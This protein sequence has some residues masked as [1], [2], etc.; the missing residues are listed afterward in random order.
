MKYTT[1]TLQLAWTSNRSRILMKCFNQTWLFKL[2]LAFEIFAASAC[3]PSSFADKAESLGIAN[4]SGKSIFAVLSYDLPS[5]SYPIQSSS[6]AQ[7]EI[8][9]TA[10]LETT[11]TWREQ[12]EL[13][14]HGTLTAYI[15]PL[16]SVKSIQYNYLQPPKPEWVLTKIY[17]TVN[18][19][20]STDKRTYQD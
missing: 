18:N 15:L 12:I 20:D 10:R 16:D 9:E 14:V 4:R 13:T 1:Y 6:T 3:K 8:G 5:L 17:I 19:L 7:A 11:K 2:W